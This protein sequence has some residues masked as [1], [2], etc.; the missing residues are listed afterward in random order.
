MGSILDEVG[1]TATLVNALGQHTILNG[2]L[3]LRHDLR[4]KWII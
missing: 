3:C 1:T 2:P 4:E